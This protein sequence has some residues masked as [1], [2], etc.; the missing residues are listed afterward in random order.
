MTPSPNTSALDNLLVSVAATS[1]TDAWAVGFS[2]PVGSASTTSSLIEHW[3]GSS[4][5]IVPGPAGT[6]LW[7]VTATSATNAWA[8]GDN[9]NGLQILHWNG[10]SWLPTPGPTP[11]VVLAGVPVVTATSTTNA[12]LAASISVNGIVAP[13][14]ARWNGTSWTQVPPV[15]VSGENDVH[16]VASSS[17][18]DVWLV[19]D[20][21]PSGQSRTLT[22]HGNGTSW[23]VTPS[24]SPGTAGNVLNSVT[25]TSASNAWAVG[26][27]TLST[28]NDATLIEHWNGI[29]LDGNPQPLTG[30]QH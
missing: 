13:Y 8:V 23:T 22:Q 21:V 14:T 2:F 4:W 12:W 30:R 6:V 19:G 24:P 27:V 25:E 1:A 16:G 15:S 20:T 3:N 17:A 9:T 29:G 11:S 18:T 26:L 28:E 7:S 10:T 5:T